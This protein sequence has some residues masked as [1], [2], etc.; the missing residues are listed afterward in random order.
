MSTRKTPKKPRRRIADKPGSAPHRIP[1]PPREAVLEVLREQARP[2]PRKEL[3]Q[4]L[5]LPAQKQQQAM[6]NRLRAMIRDGQI[7]LNR[8]DQYCLLDRLD[9]IS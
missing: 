5:S 7:I 1:I 3:M 4:A 6:D 2:V 9:V 8:N